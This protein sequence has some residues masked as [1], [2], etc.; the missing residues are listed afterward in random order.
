MRWLT[1]EEID[2]SLFED[3]G[4]DHNQR[5]WIVRND[6][7]DQGPRLN[8]E[9]N[10]ASIRSRSKRRSKVVDEPQSKRWSSVVELDRSLNRLFA[11][12][13]GGVGLCRSFV[14]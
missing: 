10:W 3:P 8:C 6:W 14:P 7:F 11:I 2:R 5:M 9:G 13:D 12:D 4:R 1:I